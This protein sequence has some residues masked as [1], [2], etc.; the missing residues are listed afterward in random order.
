MNEQRIREIVREE[1]QRMKEEAANE[2]TAQQLNRPKPTTIC[3]DAKAESIGGMETLHLLI[4]ERIV[5]N[6]KSNNV[7]HK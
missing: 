1:L 5:A 4:Q 2:T 7:V 3:V 6:C